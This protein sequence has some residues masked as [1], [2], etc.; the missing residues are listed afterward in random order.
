MNDDT[1]SMQS[2]PLHPSD[3]L[4]KDNRF[5]NS[6]S[7]IGTDKPPIPGSAKRV[8]SKKM[9]INE[10]DTVSIPDF[11]HLQIIAAGSP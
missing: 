5:K 8:P 6:R 10:N 11:D 9:K 4:T 3:S 1:I 2:V 7:T